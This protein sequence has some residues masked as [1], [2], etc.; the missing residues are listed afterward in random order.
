MNAQTTLEFMIILIALMSF[1]VLIVGKYIIL[2]HNQIVAFDN[3]KNSINTIHI[4]SNSTTFYDNY[5]MNITAYLQN[6]IYINKSNNFDILFSYPGNYR[7][8]KIIFSSNNAH[9]IPSYIYN[10]SGSYIKIIQTSIIPNSTGTTKIEVN[11]S[12]TMFYQNNQT[13][14]SY[15]LSALS[16]A[17]AEP[18]LNSTNNTNNLQFL[19]SIKNRS[20]KI[21][22]NLSANKNITKAYMWS[23]CVYIN[24]QG[25]PKDEVQECGANTYGFR[26]DVYPQCMVGYFERYYCI[27][28]GNMSNVGVQNITNRKSNIYKFDLFINASGIQGDSYLSNIKTTNSLVEGN[29]TYGISSIKSVYV[30]PFNQNHNYIVLNKFY[31]KYL[32]N[33]TYYNNY[34]NN[35]SSL[36]SILQI[37]N[38][39]KVSSASVNYV[40]NKVNLVNNYIN[41]ILNESSV[42][43]TNCTLNQNMFLC[44]SEYPFQYNITTQIFNKKIN[45]TVNYEGSIIHI[46]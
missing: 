7:I 46:V 1:S 26:E 29:G 6:I 20:E 11:V 32:I 2:Q 28:L 38:D 8:N 30:P 44:N 19:A 5:R 42:N 39:S 16:Y 35:F 22:Y 23:H 14:R 41:K 43:V 10:I 13:T 21:A 27:A 12:V 36:I 37:Y 24:N 15:N 34:I 4:S 18:L 33:S 25:Q 17:E 40:S 9:I 45:K 31:D 3:I